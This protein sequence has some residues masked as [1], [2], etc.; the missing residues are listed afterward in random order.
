MGGYASKPVASYTEVRGS[1]SEAPGEG[2][3]I[4]NVGSSYSVSGNRETGRRREGDP[5]QV[6]FAVVSGGD[7]LSSKRRWWAAWGPLGVGGGRHGSKEGEA[8][9]KNH[10]PSVASGPFRERTDSFF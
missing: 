7:G 4:A 9:A 5:G 6:S 1:A 8:C 3:R 10:P 2:F